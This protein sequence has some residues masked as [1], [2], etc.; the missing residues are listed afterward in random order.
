MSTSGPRPES[1]IKMPSAVFS[2]I[3]YC[4]PAKKGTVKHRG[5]LQLK[6]LRLDA[7]IKKKMVP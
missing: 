5:K 7:K 4:V 3:G 6:F 2:V 1:T